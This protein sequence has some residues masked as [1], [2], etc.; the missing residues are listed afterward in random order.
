[1][2][3]AIRKPGIHVRWKTVTY[4]SVAL[5]I[6]AALALLFLGMR[7]AFPQFTDNG[8]KAAGN[9]AGKILER[10]AGMAPPSGTGVSTAQQACFTALDGTVKVKREAAIPG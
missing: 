7:M 4:R 8:V 6:L 5:I 1:M 2:S 10:V 3:S 9:V